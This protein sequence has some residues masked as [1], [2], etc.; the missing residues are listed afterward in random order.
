MNN[1]HRKFVALAGIA[2]GAS[3][4][5]LAIAAADADAQEMQR[6]CCND[7]V[8]HGFIKVGDLWNPTTCGN[9]QKIEYNQCY[10]ER[11]D[12]VAVGGTLEVCASASTPSGWTQVS[13]TWNPTKCG[14]PTNIVDNVKT[15]KRDR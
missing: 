10:I 4:F 13:A 2:L 6:V 8:P 1:T 11:Y 15:I 9:P 12:S 14:N 5:V 3:F 7:P